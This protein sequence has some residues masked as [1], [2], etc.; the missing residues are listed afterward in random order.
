MKHSA[1]LFLIIRLLVAQDYSDFDLGFK[2]SI[3]E[4]KNKQNFI[5]IGIIDNDST[6]YT[7]LWQ[8]NTGSFIS[9]EFNSFSELKSINYGLYKSLVMYNAYSYDFKLRYHLDNN[10]V[11]FSPGFNAL[12]T[13]ISLNIPI[14][15]DLDK[16]YNYFEGSL[17]IYIIL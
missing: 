2:L 6:K 7:H 3:I 9:L 11:S 8:F 4:G 10:G 17:N 1:I 5:E 16:N 13:R 15:K 14:F 12:F